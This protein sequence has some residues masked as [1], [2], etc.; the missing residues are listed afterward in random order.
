MD[1]VLRYLII[2][3]WVTISPYVIFKVIMNSIH[4]HDGLHII[5]RE[6][7]DDPWAYHCM[8]GMHEWL[9]YCELFSMEAVNI[10]LGFEPNTFFG[11]DLTSDGNYTKVFVIINVFIMVVIFVTI[12]ICCG[13]CCR[14]R[15]RRCC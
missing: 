5:H 2:I 3:S 7:E 8:K 15:C 13:P 1:L 6:C 12:V 14:R 11:L 10:F 9:Q 4:N